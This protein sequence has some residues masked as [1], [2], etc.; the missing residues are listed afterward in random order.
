MP[1]SI[2]GDGA[3]TG[4]TT[5]YSFDQ[6]V[7]V[8]GTVTYE[9]VTNVDSIGVITA[10]NGIEVTGGNVHIAGVGATIGVTTAYISSINDLGY[11][12]AGPLS[13]RNLIDNGAMRVAQRGT[14]ETQSQYSNYPICD[15]WRVQLDNASQATFTQETSGGPSGFPTF[16]KWNVDSVDSSIATASNVYLNQRIEGLNLQSLGYGAASAKTLTMSFYVKGN[17]TG[18]YVLEIS[19][20]N[21]SRHIAKTYT[22][23]TADTWEYKTITFPGDTTNSITDSNSE[24]FRIKWWLQAGT[25]FTTGTLPAN[26]A[27]ESNVN[28]AAGQSVNLHDDA[29]ANW[30]ITGVQL[31]VGERAT[32]FEHRSYGDELARCQRYYQIILDNDGTNPDVIGVFAGR[33]ASTTSIVFTVPLAVPMRSEPVMTGST[34]GTIYAYSGGARVD[35]GGTGTLTLNSANEWSP[36]TS[37]VLLIA[38][39]FTV[40]DD[41]IYTVGGVGDGAY[42]FLSAEL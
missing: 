3:I 23:D 33:S 2:S 9:D 40:T 24:G 11:P 19:R 21:E 35:N 41:R 28:R 10:R 42:W 6:S 39:G 26:W 29:G 13:N 7:S 12:S 15:R 31:E 27:A 14:T 22:I 1:I 18:T 38:N 34:V 25:N 4:A 37:H 8:G 36:Y 17:R 32:P 30:N 16:F 20:P 5:S